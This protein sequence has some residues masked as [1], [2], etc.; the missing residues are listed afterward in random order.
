MPPALRRS[1]EDLR[2]LAVL[3][4]GK[5]ELPGKDGRESRRIG[6]C[7]QRLHRHPVNTVQD[8]APGV[9]VLPKE[10]DPVIQGGDRNTPVHAE[11]SHRNCPVQIFLQD[12]ENKAE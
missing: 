3:Q 5:T 1:R 4:E 6:N 11:I 12:C 8:R 2:R 7:K 10:M 9:I